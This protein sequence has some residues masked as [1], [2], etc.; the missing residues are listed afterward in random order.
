MDSILTRAGVLAGTPHGYIDLVLPEH[1]VMEQKVGRGAFSEFVGYRVR[2]GEGLSGKV[3]QTGQP[4]AINDYQT[5]PDHLPAVAAVIHAIVGVPLKSGGQ[6]IGVIGLGHTEPGRAFGPEQ[7]EVLS[8]F[9]EMASLA[10]DNARLYTAAQDE[11]VERKQ[12]GELR[13]A[14]YRIA[15]AASQAGGL[16]ELFHAVHKIIKTIM[17]ADNFYIA[18]YDEKNDLLSFPYFVDEI[19]TP[20]PPQ[21]PGKGLT[22]YVLRTAKPVLCTPEVQKELERSGEAAP[23][24]VPSPVWLGVP[25]IVEK[26]AI[27]VMAVQ[28]YSDP[29]AYNENDLWVLEFVSSEV[30]QAIDLTR[31]QEALQRE[32][33]IT[34][35]TER[36]RAEEALRKSEQRFRILAEN[37]PGVIYQ[38]KDNE[39]YTLLYVNDA[40]EALTG[41]PKEDFLEDR[42]SLVDL[43]H[44]EDGNLAPRSSIEGEKATESNTFYY[45]YRIQHKSG[46]WRWVEEWGTSVYG[47]DGAFQFFEGFITDITERKLAEAQLERSALELAALSHMGQVVAATLDLSVVLKKVID[48]ASP[49][50]QAEGI[51][52]L[53]PEGDNK[54]VF[55]AASGPAS[56]G[57]VGRLIPF[58]AG[59]AGGVMQTGRSIRITSGESEPQLY[60]EIEQYS[61]YHTR[62]LLAVPLN[63]GGEVIGVM[64]AVHTQPNAFTADDQRLLESAANWAAIAIRNARQHEHTQRRLQESEA[65]AAISRA[66]NQTLDLQLTLQLIVDSARQV[67]PAS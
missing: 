66:L 27:G 40:I 49:L 65:M 8:R 21:K 46:E 34:D 58:M 55:A 6:T 50:L 60:R 53:L 17:P 7:I 51:S 47:E 14:I 16:D 13:N 57:L 19:D 2:P 59:A 9:A 39:R 42:I 35:P 41:Y 63:L 62:S 56:A 32:T 26:K 64:E 22:E 29:N 31:A 4:L 30:A 15:Q 52:I 37:I 1:S 45:S 67:I 43:H 28:H 25:L 11:L 10:L 18:V 61:E 3:W 38:C 44:P 24:G 12:A 48:E 33:V 5:W 54:L 20:S 23:V 36:K